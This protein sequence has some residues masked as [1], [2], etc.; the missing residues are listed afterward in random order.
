MSILPA[1]DKALWNLLTEEVSRTLWTR[2]MILSSMGDDSRFVRKVMVDPVE[3]E[4]EEVETVIVQ[5]LAVGPLLGPV[6]EGLGILDLEADPS[7][8][9]HPDMD[10]EAVPRAAINQVS[11][12]GNRSG[13]HLVYCSSFFLIWMIPPS[14][15]FCSFT[16]QWSHW[17]PNIPLQNFNF[18]RYFS[19]SCSKSRQELMSIPNQSS[20]AI[21]NYYFVSVRL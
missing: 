9:L 2:K 8:D 7:L 12:W 19:Q 20:V 6:P 17:T 1:K 21:S 4:E 10:H 13:T 16:I 11:L 14:Q 15:S 18:V 5:I 3:A